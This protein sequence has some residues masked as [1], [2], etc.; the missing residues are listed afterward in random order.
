MCIRDRYRRHSWEVRYKVA[1]SKRQS[2]RDSGAFF[3]GGGGGAASS[4]RSSSSGGGGKVK[5][6]VVV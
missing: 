1:E 2:D 4:E 6:A 3:F 5:R